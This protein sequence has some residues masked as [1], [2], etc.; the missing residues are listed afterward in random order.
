MPFISTSDGKQLYCNDWG[1]G[2]P[3]VFI[4][5]WPL[6]SQMWEY[7]IPYFVPQ[8]FRTIT[9]D[10]RGF[11]RS[12]HPW[13]GYG[14]DTLAR[15]LLDVLEQFD[16]RDVALV[17]FSM[18]GG[19]VAR[20]LTR[21]GTDRVSRVA[22]ISSVT[23]YLLKTDD[24]P[25]GVDASVFEETVTS[26]Q[27]DRPAFLAA[28]GKKLFGAGL[29]KHPVSTELLNWA[30]NLALPASPKATLDCAR[31]FAS[32]DFREDMRSFTCPTLIIHGDA[33]QTVPIKA[34]SE[35]TAKLIPKA[36]YTVYEGE[37]HGLFFT[38]KD[39]LNSDLST[40]LAE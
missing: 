14:Y 27:T 28:H 31:A 32:T 13:E 35:R 22:L 16:L 17:G 2:R 30:W 40:F 38:A 29:L 36:R 1:R 9:Y 5:G 33:D 4:H 11:G 6:D 8:G 23:P 25:Q 19:E 7:Q 10:R 26:L 18:G 20:F 37:P 24:N 3:V 39:R 12:S 15:D 21:Y 34:S